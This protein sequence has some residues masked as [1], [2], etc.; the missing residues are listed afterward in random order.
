MNE[1]DA[2]FPAKTPRRTFKKVITLVRLTRVL[3]TLVLAI[4]IVSF[5]IGVARPETGV[6]EKIVLLAL[7]AGC[8]CLAARVSTWATRAASAA[9]ARL[10]RP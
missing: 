1:A 8:I 10:L 3:L 2:T 4:F 6:V 9:Q 7:I 5:I